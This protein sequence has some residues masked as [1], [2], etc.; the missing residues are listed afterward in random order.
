MN[1]KGDIAWSQ[2]ALW[3]IA[4]VLII[5]LVMFLIDLP[6]LRWINYLPGLDEDG[7][8]QEV[9]KPVEVTSEADSVSCD[10]VGELS[11][12]SGGTIEN[13]VNWQG[14]WRAIIVD[15]EESLFYIKGNSLDNAKIYFADYKK[16]VGSVFNN[17]IHFEGDLFDERSKL[18]REL[19]FD[20]FSRHP[21]SYQEDFN[22]NILELEGAKIVGLGICGVENNA[23]FEN[24]FERIEEVFISQ[25][26][27]G[28]PY[29]DQKIEGIDK[30]YL[31]KKSKG[32]AWIRASDSLIDSYV[33]ILFMDGSVWI[34][35]YYSNRYFAEKLN[36]QVS[37]KW[38]FF[39]IK[40]FTGV[41]DYEE[42]D[43]FQTNLYVDE[44]D[45]RK[46]FN[47]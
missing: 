25:D 32:Y 30:F 44:D 18:R 34:D 21:Y 26:L 13:L 28:I 33:G 5:I 7:G 6:F 22:E 23:R 40:S 15:G 37:L 42:G 45:L 8:D 24:E 3:I 11:S 36:D 29:V 31:Q 35:E 1:K 27:I 19:W 46:F 41:Y 39:A 9:D 17:A 14:D 2:M 10:K 47:G 4:V 38:S 12:D 20:F 43:I 16:P